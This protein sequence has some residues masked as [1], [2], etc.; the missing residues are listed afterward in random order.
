MISSF[1]I[2]IFF[3]PFSFSFLAITI[4][5]FSPLFNIFLLFCPSIKSY[6][7]FLGLLKLSKVKSVIQLFVFYC[8]SI[9]L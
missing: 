7:S 1:D 3:K 5:N 2:E 9:Y 6:E 8:K 4:F